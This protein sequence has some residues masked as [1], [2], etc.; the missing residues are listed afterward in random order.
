MGNTILGIV[1]SYSKFKMIQNYIESSQYQ[2]SMEFEKLKS[3]INL[4]AFW[5]VN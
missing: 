2:E 4:L 5:S 1:Y 3:L